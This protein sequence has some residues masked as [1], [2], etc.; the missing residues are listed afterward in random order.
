MRDVIRL[1]GAIKRGSPIE[2]P[3]SA[4]GVFRELVTTD[5][6][7]D[8]PLTLRTMMRRPDYRELSTPKLAVGDPAF[9]FELPKHDFCNGTA[10]ATGATVRLSEFRGVQPVALIFGS[11]T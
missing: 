8:S 1:G 2:G 9:D 7:K 5:T 6:P 11:Y 3:S 10:V 4:F